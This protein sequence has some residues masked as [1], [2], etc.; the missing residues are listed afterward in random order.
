MSEISINC[1]LFAVFYDRDC[2]EE[3]PSAFL[4]LLRSPARSLLLSLCS[5]RKQQRE[6][7]QGLRALDQPRRG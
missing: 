1:T 5:K 3:K 2:S 6:G 7:N 4:F